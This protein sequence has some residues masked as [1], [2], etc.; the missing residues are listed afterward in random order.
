MIYFR[1]AAATIVVLLGSGMFFLLWIS[2]G[3]AFLLPPENWRL[4]TGNVL[5]GIAGAVMLVSGSLKLAHVPLVVAEMTALGLPGWKLE[6]VGALEVLSGVL[7]LL[8]RLR[9]L[10]LPFASAYLGAAICAHVQIGQY[11]A[12]LPTMA[13]LGACWL[14]AGLRHPH[15]LWSV[16]SRPQVL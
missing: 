13:I 11:F 5:I 2:T 6:L 14:G 15:L 9:S 16:S 4:R 3:R 8:P 1:L 7:F 12:V 10:G